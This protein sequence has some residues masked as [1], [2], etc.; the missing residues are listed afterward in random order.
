[1]QNMFIWDSIDMII[2]IKHLGTNG[3]TFV[4]RMELPLVTAVP[5]QI[6]P[7]V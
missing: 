6:T 3:L 2:C 5:G 4:E 1:M 7:T